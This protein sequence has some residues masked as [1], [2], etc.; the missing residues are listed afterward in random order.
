MS[1]GAGSDEGAGQLDRILTTHTGS[2][3]RPPELEAD[4]IRREQGRPVDE[5]RFAAARRDGIAA[6]MREQADNGLDIVNDGEFDKNSWITYIYYRITGIE[7]R[8]YAFDPERVLEAIPPTFDRTRTGNVREEL[9]RFVPFYARDWSSGVGTGWVCTGP[10]SYDPAAIDEHLADVRAAADR[11]GQAADMP[12]RP[13]FITAM[14]PGS[15]HWIRNEYYVSEEDF[16]VAFADALRQEY[17][18]II[19]AG[20]YLQ[21]DDAVLW[22]QRATITMLGGTQ[23]DYDA[24]ADIR[25]AALNRALEGIPTERIRYHVC[26]GSGHEA[27][28]VDAGLR[29]VLPAILKV[30]WGALL[31]EQANAGHEHEWAV[32]RDFALPEG[33]ML[34][35]GVVTHHT[36]VVEHPDLVAQ[37]LVRLAGAVGPDRIMAGTDCGFAQTAGKSR[38]QPWTQWAK[39]RALVAGAAQASAE[40]W[41]R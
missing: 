4:L 29:E 14:S 32:W 28:V 21:V 34:V 36:H 8:E 17:L 39:L 24:W 18:K 19:E 27:K 10:I 6:V 9:N 25:V 35:P 41:P 37:R 1:G 22:R 33:R 38:V 16:V 13:V 23:R 20:F 3:I 7:T 11:L 31:I 5:E 26:S 12:G 30:R 40:L 15:L 2:L